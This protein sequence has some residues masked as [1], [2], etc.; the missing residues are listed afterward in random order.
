MNVL[1]YRFGAYRRMHVGEYVNV[2]DT[3]SYQLAGHVLS[4]EWLGHV[5][6]L[7]ARQ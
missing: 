2:C 1:D 7:T 5:D 6:R 4:A 3:V